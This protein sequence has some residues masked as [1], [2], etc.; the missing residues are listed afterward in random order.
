[1]KPLS[2]LMASDDFLPAGTG[3]GTHIKILAPELVKRGHS[4]S[5][6]TS[7][8]RGEPA[9]EVWEGVKIFRVFSVPAY[10]FYQALPSRDT[11]LRV[12]REVR[13]DLIHHH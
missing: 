7:R 11:L 1:M 3:V 8:R 13:P 10:G 2:I 9:E 6:I 5:V 4:V 12:I